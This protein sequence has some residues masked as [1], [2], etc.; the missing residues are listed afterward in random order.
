MMTLN[1]SNLEKPHQFVTMKNFDDR[2]T[3]I[4]IDRYSRQI[5]FL[6]GEQKEIDM[7]SEHIPGWIERGRPDRG[8][9]DVGS[10]RC[11]QPIPQHP[12]RIVAGI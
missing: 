12:L 3:Y 2:Q 9:F 11:G 10:P 7:I 8:F 5:P 1:Q 6:P 4:A